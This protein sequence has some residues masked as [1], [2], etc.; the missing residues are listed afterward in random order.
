MTTREKLQ[1]LLT[2][3][4]ADGE[5]NSQFAMLSRL[6]Y[7]ASAAVRGMTA[8]QL[9]AF[10]G[11]AA[12]RILL[13]LARD[14]KAQVRMEAYDS[15]AA[16]DT[17]ETFRFLQNA[18]GAERDALARSYAILSCGDVFS[19]LPETR[20]Q[21]DAFHT[22]LNAQLSAERQ[23]HCIL[24]CCYALIQLGDQGEFSRLLSFLSAQDHRIR[25]AVLEHLAQ[26]PW[27]DDREA[28]CCAVVHTAACDPSFAVRDR[29]QR[30]L[31]Q[32]AECPET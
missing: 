16:Y 20:A 25:C 6:S 13:R 19:Q 18:I 32:L 21:Q 27:P 17:G 9:A 4:D 14:K 10:D 26:L 28:I 29:A 7:D 2:R 8:A 11:P 23:P 31:A 30:L 15:L 1:W 12:N 24:A 22:F 5:G 3:A